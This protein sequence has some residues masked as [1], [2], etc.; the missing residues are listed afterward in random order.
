MDD[1][2]RTIA[3]YESIKDRLTADTFDN[4]FLFVIRKFLFI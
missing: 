4:G 3:N 1:G 2:T